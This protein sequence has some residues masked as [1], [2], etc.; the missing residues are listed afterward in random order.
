MRATWLVFRRELG[1][2]FS[3]PL[4]YLIAAGF[5]LLTGVTFNN[6][7]AFSI[8]YR[9]VDPA[10]IPNQ[11]ATVMILFAPLLTMRLLAEEQR[12]GTLE[13]LL[14]SP[15]TDTAIVLGKFLSAWTY[16]SILLALTLI[17][18]VILVQIAFPDLGHTAGAYIGIWLYGGAALAVGVLFSALTENQILSAFLATTT[19][20][21]LYF[22]DGLGQI[23]ASVELAQVIFNLTLRGHFSP[24]F[25]IG[26][27]R[28]EDIVYFA[29]IITLS[30]F[31]TIQIVNSR[32]WR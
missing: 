15:I 13:L 29:G 28:G 7:L 22:G 25:A 1:Q 16:Y 12:E 32:R 6:D 27:V 9:P 30:L 14:T 17:Y 8:G 5:L 20:L 2:Y 31:V 24:S 23:V 26:L 18:Q 4:A 19:L 10:L 11:L 3:S 21:L